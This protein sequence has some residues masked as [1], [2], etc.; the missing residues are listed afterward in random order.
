MTLQQIGL[1]RTTAYNDI[2]IRKGNPLCVAPRVGYY[3]FFLLQIV[4]PRNT[5]IQFQLFQQ[6]R[7]HAEFA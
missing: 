4:R 1:L 5:R 3:A 7:T 2:S 6:S